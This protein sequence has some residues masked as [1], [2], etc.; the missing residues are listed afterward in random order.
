MQT[1]A[2][3]LFA[4]PGGNR[5]AVFTQ[6]KAALQLKPAPANGRGVFEKSCASC[7]RLNQQGIAV[8]PDLFD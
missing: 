2:Q 7:H 8:G 1:R 5:E 4:A 3:K 6:T